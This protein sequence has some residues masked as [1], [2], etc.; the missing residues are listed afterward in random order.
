MLESALRMS[1]VALVR[2]TSAAIA[3]CRPPK[4]SAAARVDPLA[5]RPEPGYG[6][7]VVPLRY[8][9]AQTII[10]L[11]DSFADQ[12]RHGARRCRRATCC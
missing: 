2:D 12:A 7:T 5:T 1:N 9:S 11:L 3:S 8:V 10:K 6:I 4:R